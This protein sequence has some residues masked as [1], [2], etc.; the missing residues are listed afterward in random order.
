MTVVMS[1]QPQPPHQET[2][3]SLASGGSG[4]LQQVFSART[5]GISRL[6][7]HLG[8]VLFLLVIVVVVAVRRRRAQSKWDPNVPV[9]VSH[10]PSLA[11]SPDDIVL[12]SAKQQKR[13]CELQ[14]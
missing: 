1:Y 5:F 2:T 10:I 14:R 4:L 9:D 6:M 3:K 12:S 8:L 13:A 7:L 11:M